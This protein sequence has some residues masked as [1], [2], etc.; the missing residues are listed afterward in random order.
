M[1]A[2]YRF[3]EYTVHHNPE[4][5]VTGRARCIDAGGL[6]LWHSGSSTDLGALT[7]AICAHN[8]KSAHTVFR[9]TV[10][11]VVVVVPVKWDGE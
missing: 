8:E 7:K 10:T 9:R 6:C 1:R 4:V 2:A 5:L 11:D 3:R